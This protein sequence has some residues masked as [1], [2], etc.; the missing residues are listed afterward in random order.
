M[1][2]DF[3][4]LLIELGCNKAEATTFSVLAKYP[5]GVTVLDL[6]RELNLP[7]PTIYTHMETFSKLGIAKKGVKEN[8]SFFYPES[9]GIL[10]QVLDEKITSL[11]K[12]KKI[13]GELFEETSASSFKPKFFVYEGPKSYESVWRDILR[14]KEETFWI[15][16]VKDMLKRVSKDKLEEFHHER[17]RRN[18]WMNVLWPDKS[19]LDI[20]NSPFLLSPDE[21]VS[22]RRVKILPKGF[23][24]D[25][26]YGV[27]GNKVAFI[28]SG[29]EDYA[30]VIE[31][32]ELSQTLKKQFDF[33]WKI[34]S[35]Y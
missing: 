31:S 32:K 2:T 3:L 18:I 9:R 13:L 26:G 14:T 34:S 15:W 4:N 35:K 1:K 28:S 27:Y 19:K 16:P 33:F 23:D 30:F 12:S 22:L 21:K 20:K 29:R 5:G 25:I 10:E 7:R 24:Q 11:S 6:S 17:I 8:T